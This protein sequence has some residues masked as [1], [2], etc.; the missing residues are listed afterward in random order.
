M[1]VSPTPIPVKRE[2]RRLF[3]AGAALAVLAAAG[4]GFL[5]SEAF[6]DSSGAP[7]LGSGVTAT[8]TR[9]VAPFDSVELA[10]ADSVTIQV[11]PA[12]SVVVQADDNLLANVTTRVDDGRL[13]IATTRSFTT[14]TPMSVALTVPSL[15]SLTLSGSGAVTADGIEAS[16][17]RI[18][19]SGNGL[20]RA[21]GSVATLDVDLAGSGDAEL[22]GLAAQDVH[23]VLSGTG[24]IVVDAAQTLD[25]EIPGNGAILYTGSATVTKSVTGTGSITS[26]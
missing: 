19:L 25:A 3:L 2:P 12:Q 6:N 22:A 7:V 17:L 10:G 20:L 8:E 23:A 21:T 9:A 15:E 24:R 1:T 14:A 11:G 13:V 18:S 4:A 26:G 16:A 5:L